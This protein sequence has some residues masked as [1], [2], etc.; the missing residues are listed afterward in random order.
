MFLWVCFG[1]VCWVLGFRDRLG[2]AI[3]K[4][5]QVELS[6]LFLAYSGSV[7]IENIYDYSM[8]SA[9][10]IIIGFYLIKGNNSIIKGIKNF[11]IL[12]PFI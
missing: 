3:L 7:G 6:G 1:L 5:R 2:S 8:R 9:C 11:L 12:C 4:I 10:E